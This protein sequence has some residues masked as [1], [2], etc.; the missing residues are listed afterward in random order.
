MK[1]P[2]EKNKGCQMK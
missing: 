2:I 1:L